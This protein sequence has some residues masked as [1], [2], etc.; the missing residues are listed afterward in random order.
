MKLPVIA[1]SL[2]IIDNRQ[3]RVL[4]CQDLVNLVVPAYIEIL[5]PIEID[6]N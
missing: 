3:I 2:S 6:Q 4:I 1:T 5:V